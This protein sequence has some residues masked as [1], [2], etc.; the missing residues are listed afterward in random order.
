MVPA[1]QHADGAYV[2]VLHQNHKFERLS[3]VRNGGF[4]RAAAHHD[5]DAFGVGRH[6]N[7]FLKDRNHAVFA[8][9]A[10]GVV[11]V[12]IGFGVALQCRIE[13]QALWR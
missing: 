8:T 4:I 9:R 11:I 12:H 13:E 7:G 2:G 5:F 3:S 10:L 6:R 1:W